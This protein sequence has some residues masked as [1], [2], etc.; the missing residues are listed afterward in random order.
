VLPQ[1]THV[2]VVCSTEVRRVIRELHDAWSSHPNCL[3][4]F[5][6]KANPLNAVLKVVRDA[7]MGCETASLGEFTMAE[8]VFPA[9]RI[10]FDSPAKTVEELRH[11]VYQNVYV[12]LDNFEE[13]ERVANM[14]REKPVCATIGLRINPQLG[15]GTIGALS[16]GAATSKFGIGLNDF[17]REIVD[18]YAAHEFLSM[19]HVHTGSQGIG[20]TMMVEGVKS[21]VNLAQEIGP[22][23]SV[24]DIGGGLPVN[25]TSDDYTPSMKGYVSSL[26]IS[27]PELFSG[28]YKLITEFGRSIVAKAGFLASRVEYTKM[29][30]NRRIIQQH[31]GA[32]LAVR[33]VWAPEVWKL[34][35]DVY[36]ERGELK[37]EDMH[38]TDVA[39]PCCF[40][41][42]LVASNVLLPRAAA[43][44]DIVVVKDTGAY[45]HSSFSHYNL[46]QPPPC[47]L[48]DEDGDVLTLIKAKQTID[49]AIAIMM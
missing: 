8:R 24:V 23:I 33:T 14:H 39:G 38:E 9:N 25:F 16:T 11:V 10:V 6:A 21:I 35:V 15:Y 19:I 41:G 45:Y 1:E 31:I 44:R 2:F 36:N 12:N 4:A 47:Y 5:A 20:L 46:R 40:G 37:T 29:A 22:Q 17:R 27:V 30:G 43:L 42:D 18:A 7:G 26:Q 28:K 3:H 49:E 13:L 32:D 34:R 48:Y